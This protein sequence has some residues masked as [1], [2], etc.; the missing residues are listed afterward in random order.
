MERHYVA[1]DPHFPQESRMLASQ[2]ANVQAVSSP[3][4][5]SFNSEPTD[6]GEVGVEAQDISSSVQKIKSTSFTLRNICPWP[7]KSL[8]TKEY[9]TFFL[10]VLSHCLVHTS[11]CKA[12]LSLISPLNFIHLTDWLLK[13]LLL[14]VLPVFPDATKK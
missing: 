6:Q 8:E 9:F 7:Q 1:E 13:L 10:F 11:L 5:L 4:K 2:M 14:M 12:L 3:V